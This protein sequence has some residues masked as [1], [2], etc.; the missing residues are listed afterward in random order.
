MYVSVHYIYVHIHSYIHNI[1]NWDYEKAQGINYL[2]F[3]LQEITYVNMLDY[4]LLNL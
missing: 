3:Y 2:Q 4:S 1:E